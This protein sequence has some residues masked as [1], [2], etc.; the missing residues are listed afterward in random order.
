M[1]VVS[2]PRRRQFPYTPLLALLF[3]LIPIHDRWGSRAAPP[4]KIA[5]SELRISQAPRASA[6]KQ[7]PEPSKELIR[8][9][10][11]R[12]HLAGYRGQHVKIAILDSGFRGYQ[13]FLGKAL[14]ATT[15][16]HSFRRD[17]NLEAK[18]SQHGILCGEVVH[19]L[20]PDADLLLANWEPDQPEQFLNAVRWAREQGASPGSWVAAARPVTCFVSP[21]PAIRPCDTGAANS[22]TAAMASMSGCQGKKIICSGPGEANGFPSSYTGR[23][24]RTM[25]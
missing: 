10:V 7:V 19:A 8:L 15:L 16:V 24:K 6:S 14:P 17:G 1:P 9:G 2:P 18:D 22:A 4:E 13:S 25:T 23:K 21:V 5:R 3:A 12:W 20:A 11:D